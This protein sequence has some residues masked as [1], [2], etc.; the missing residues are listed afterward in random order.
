M[1]VEYRVV[2]WAAMRWG[3]LKGGWMV[4]SGTVCMGELEHL[5]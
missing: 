3:W 5:S 2:T 1:R 4:F